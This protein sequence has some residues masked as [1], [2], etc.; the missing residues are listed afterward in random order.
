MKK[1]KGDMITFFIMTFLAAIMIFICLN[2]IIGTF[3]VI[4][5]NVE[6]I[7]GADVRIFAPQDKVQNFML[8]ELIT[9]DKDYS[10]YE[11]NDFLSTQAKY[12][13]KGR[14]KW[15]NYPFHINSYEDE[16]HIQ[17]TIMD[18]S[19]F[20]GNEIILPVS[21]SPSYSIGDMIE[22]KIGENDYDFK[23]AGFNEDFIYGSPMN[24]GIY[25][26]YVSD[27][28]YNQIEFENP[29]TA[30]HNKDYKLLLSKDA[31]NRG[32]VG[33]DKA[34][35]C[36]NEL[37]N[38]VNSYKNSHPEYTEEVTGSF[39]PVDM[40]KTASMILPF[41]FIAIILMFAFIIL[42]IAFVI[43]DFSVKNFIMDNMKNTGIM[44]AG[45][46]T[47]KELILILLI[48]LLLVSASGCALGV[49]I[50][51]L[52]QKQVGFIMLF[53][54]GLSWNQGVN[55]PLM[56]GVLLGICSA[57]TV[58]TLILGREYKKTSVLD[59]LRGGINTHNFKKNLFSFDKTHM[60]L[61]LT[62]A[63]K[64]TFGKFKSR[65]GVIIIMAVLAF[66]ASMGFGI[67]ENLGKDTDALLKISGIDLCDADT[68]WE[69]NIESSISSLSTVDYLYN[70]AWMGF[71][72]K[73]GKKNKAIT[74]CVISDPSVMDPDM[75]VEGRWPLY[76]NEISLAT[77]SANTL[78]VSVGD[79]VTVRNGEEEASYL[80]SGIGQTF[81][82][83]GLM[84]YM[85]EEGYERIGRPLNAKTVM[86]FLKDKYKYKDFEKQFK[87]IYPDKEI[88][89]SYASTGSLFTLLKT[90]M[91]AI[92]GIIMFI[93]IFIVALAE[94]LL[95]RTQITKEWKNLGVNKALG[96]TSNQLILQIMM[97]NLPSILIGIVLG[98]IAV[99][100]FG[101]KVCLLMFAIFGF[102]K[103]RFVLSP[104]SYVIVAAVIVSVA[105]LV[106]WINGR[107]IRKLEPVKMITEE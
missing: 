61:T 49:M 90:S 59:A 52:I 87:E 77:Q 102:R 98:L 92:L 29:T 64:E 10:D 30:I 39:I 65:I 51:A 99:T 50:G 35:E 74:T 68:L 67:Y 81:Q 41:I 58:F 55:V 106:S 83:M 14:T 26:V 15:A 47:V 40:L 100:F 4:D 85:S 72:Y 45:G 96:F 27:K 6:A 5:T 105:M 86:I 16:R 2:L 42:L 95:I 71:D 62:L 13:K 60:P 57:I 19:K 31:K 24:M 11:I 93:T 8:E 89:D 3:R 56:F 46:Y 22:I 17:T 7:N 103:V 66:S 80:V 36:F 28:M 18:P 37:T 76:S 53:L 34:D 84:A 43:I 101:G 21:L 63:L 12:R 54:L 75:M 33:D 91:G 9:G 38:Q 82:N 32:V 23:V 20:S 69:E 107:R 94:A 88:N 70:E 1:Q 44:E 79:T 104:I 48:Q 25:L 78:G 73:K 97:S